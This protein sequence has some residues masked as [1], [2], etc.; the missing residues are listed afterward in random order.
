MNQKIKLSADAVPLTTE[1]G[2]LARLVQAADTVRTLQSSLTQR[3]KTPQRNSSPPDRVFQL[4][5]PELRAC[6]LQNTPAVQRALRL[7]HVGHA[8]RCHVFDPG[9]IGSPV[10][11]LWQ[12]DLTSAPL[13]V[14]ESLVEEHARILREVLDLAHIHEEAQ[15]Y[16]QSPESLQIA[17]VAA[18]RIE[19]LD[20]LWGAVS[21]LDER[22]LFRLGPFLEAVRAQDETTQ[23]RLKEAMFDAYSAHFDRLGLIGRLAPDSAECQENGCLSVGPRHTG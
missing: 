4:F 12:F 1:I 23:A 22:Y 7:E 14:L 3:L 8:E 6:G 2:L 15:E 16:G 17:G 21:S 19:D 20:S 5:E 13:A 10:L 11:E 9:A 18:E